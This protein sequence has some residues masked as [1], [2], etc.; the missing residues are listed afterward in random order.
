M[1]EATISHQNGVPFVIGTVV[2]GDK[3]GRLLGFPTANIVIAPDFAVE[4]GVWAGFAEVAGLRHPAAIS[5]GVRPTYYGEEGVRLMEVHL[6]DFEGDLY[7][8]QLSA[9]LG[10]RLRPQRWF[11][12]SEELVQQVQI[13]MER[14]G[15]WAGGAQNQRGADGRTRPSTKEGRRARRDWLRERRL[16]AAAALA[17]E[18]G[19]LSHDIVAQLAGVPTEFVIWSYPEQA[20]LH[21][22]AEHAH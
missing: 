22:L 6:L 10:R 2:P 18:A 4:D 9:E 14:A 20:D 13:D 11:G 17:E 3:R 8:R 12:G 19:N 16:S 21:R 1:T 5:I 7:G 15:R